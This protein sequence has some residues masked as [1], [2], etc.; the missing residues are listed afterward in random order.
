MCQA[1]YLYSSLRKFSRRLRAL[2]LEDESAL[3]FPL[4]T[5]VLPLLYFCTSDDLSTLTRLL[6]QPMM[7]WGWRGTRK[8][9]TGT[10]GQVSAWV[11]F[12][13]DQDHM[14]NWKGEGQIDPNWDF[15]GGPVVKTLHFHCRGTGF[16]PGR[17]TKIPY[18]VWYN[19]NFKKI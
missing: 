13:R 11:G 10:W 8:R 19:Q 6:R 15:P 14:P 5:L 16:L 17:G 18:S 2:D 1:L 4:L 3:S 12:E 9:A 7:G